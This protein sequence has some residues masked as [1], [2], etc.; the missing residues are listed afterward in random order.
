MPKLGIHNG[1]TKS[2]ARIAPGVLLLLA[3]ALISG[4]YRYIPIEPSAA[5]PNEE[6]RIRL[7]PPAA[8]RLAAEFGAS[9]STLNGQLRPQGPDSLGLSIQISRLAGGVALGDMRQMLVFGQSEVL[10]VSRREMSRGRT[11]LAAA[12]VVAVFVFLVSSVIQIGDENPGPEEPPPPPPPAG[13][14]RILRIPI[15]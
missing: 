12:G 5:R 13:L 8:S 9:T 15:H 4:C 7:S 6:V 3:L 2:R 14:Q 11:A 1:A 10:D